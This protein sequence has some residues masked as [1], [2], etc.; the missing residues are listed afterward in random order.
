[1][2]HGVKTVSITTL[3]Y[4]CWSTS[5]PNSLH[6]LLFWFLPRNL[7]RQI[8]FSR[9]KN[10]CQFQKSICCFMMH[11]FILPWGIYHKPDHMVGY[12]GLYD[13]CNKGQTKLRQ[14]HDHLSTTSRVRCMKHRANC[15]ETLITFLHIDWCMNFCYCHIVIYICV[16][17]DE[18]CS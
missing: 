11:E 5:F 7:T 18:M 13:W 6:N 2:E 4:W 8:F 12:A 1:M 3:N 15:I 17:F 16:M 14:V 9:T 10:L